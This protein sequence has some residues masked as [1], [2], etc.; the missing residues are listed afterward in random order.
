VSH[1]YFNYNGI[2]IIAGWDI[3]NQHYYLLVNYNEEVLFSNEHLICPQITLKDIMRYIKRFKID[4]PGSFYFDLAMDEEL[5][6]DN[7]IKDYR[8]NVPEK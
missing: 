1:R 5:N 3:T 2:D 4:P 7:V 6:R 8:E